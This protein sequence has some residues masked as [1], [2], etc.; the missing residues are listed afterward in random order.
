MFLLEMNGTL[1]TAVS[2]DYESYQTLTVRVSVINENNL[3]KSGV[4]LIDI[5][6]Q[7]EVVP[8]QVPT[9]SLQA[10][11]V[12]RSRLARFPAQILDSISYVR[13]VQF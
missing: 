11:H 12:L 2:F 1:R 9:Q 4:Y 13:S 3:I 8:N 10:L 7:Y 5:I 6:D